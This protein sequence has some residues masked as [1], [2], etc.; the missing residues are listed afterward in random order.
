M[1]ILRWTLFTTLFIF[2]MSTNLQADCYFDS[3]PDNEN[4]LD[5]N[6]KLSMG[7]TDCV[8]FQIW[9]G[10]AYGNSPEEIIPRSIGNYDWQQC[11]F[12]N[13]MT[14]YKLD[15]YAR[16]YLD[17]EKDDGDELHHEMVKFWGYCGT[18]VDGEFVPNGNAT[19]T[20]II[21]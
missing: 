8:G 10:P 7:G 15:Q 3:A 19:R 5:K 21:E 1:K 4:K 18:F 20:L 12:S 6:T 16:A 14:E 9:V 2:I 17:D 11:R 13:V